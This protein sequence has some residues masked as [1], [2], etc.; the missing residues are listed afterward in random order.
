[1]KADIKERSDQGAVASREV[2]NDIVSVEMVWV[3]KKSQQPF[4]QNHI[5]RSKADTNSLSP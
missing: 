5:L 2:E 3:L 4:C 1:M